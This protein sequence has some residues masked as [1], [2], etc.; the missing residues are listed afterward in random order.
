M[1]LLVDGLKARSPLCSSSGSPQAV[2]VTWFLSG[3]PYLF[4]P[5]PDPRPGTGPVESLS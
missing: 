5:V 4:P 3:R 2:S 1:L